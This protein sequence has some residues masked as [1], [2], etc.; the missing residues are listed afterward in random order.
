M[1]KNFTL[2]IFILLISTISNY[3]QVN[4]SFSATT[5]TYVPVTGGTTP[6]LINRPY[7][8][9][10]KYS[11]TYDEGIANGIPIGFTFNYNGIDY[12]TINICANGF[13]TL[14]T[15]FVSSTNNVENFYINSLKFGPLFYVYGTN[16]S[17][18]FP[19]LAGSTKPVLAPLWDDLNVQADANLRFITTGTAGSRIFTMEWAKAK[20]QYNASGSTISFELKL[21]EAANI[22]EFCYKDEGGT[23]TNA[24]ASIGITASTEIGGGF[25]SLQNTSASPTVST[26]V[27]SNSL[28]IKPANNQVYR[29]TPLTCNLPMNIH[30]QGYTNNAVNFS[31]DIPSGV[32]NFEYAVTT[33]TGDPASATSTTSNTAVVSSLQPD[34]KYYLHVRSYC[35]A[36]LQSVWQNSK[37]FK[38]AN[39]PVSLPYSE[40]FEADDPNSTALPENFREQ[41]FF[42]YNY[43]VHEW[44]S[45][46]DLP[47]YAHTGT[48]FIAHYT[49]VDKSNDW[50]YLPG[51][52]LN[53]GKTYK[54]KFYLATVTAGTK[55][56]SIE[57]KYG[58]A[59]GANA[60]LSG[61][62]FNSTNISTSDGA[63]K[64]DSAVF[65]PSASGIYFI[66]FHC[67]SEADDRDL[68]LDDI[69][70]EEI[71]SLP[72]TLLTLTG[73]VQ[74]KENL[75]HWSTV[76]EQ[77][78]TGFELQRSNDGY[79]FTK[80][81]FVK[82]KAIDGN[83]NE[84]LSYDFTDAAFTSSTNYYR[85]KQ[86]DKDGKFSYSNIVVLSNNIGTNNFITIYPNP[87]KNILN[88][89]IVPTTNSKINLVVTNVYGKN[90]LNK[91][92]N[93]GNI[94]TIVQLDV[95]QLPSGTY[96]VKIISEDGK[97]I[98]TQ[99]FIK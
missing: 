5:A 17:D 68:I 14:G 9:G 50:F 73:E 58:Q 48:Q 4:Y 39:N 95:S 91:N 41:N 47:E 99:K 93:V 23:S 21:Y 12:T 8:F 65:T 3:A 28:N 34:T 71:G 35:N 69:S 7:D 30:Y 64:A 2:I 62:L 57:V 96:F 44:E 13:A 54:L 33:S 49:S 98:A 51:F 53:V 29:F 72:V 97:E 31:W 11:F 79:N 78:N 43:D 84:K 55:P 20:W 85:L 40:G 60:M 87:V 76:T 74:H 38:A 19:E 59:I 89:K 77:N 45:R 94:E 63:Y 67:Y 42:Y 83:S 82:T 86:I 52:N 92:T 1:K 37:N 88:V 10:P 36:S 18:S 24:S 61:T 32:S 56:N 27:E 81:G 25:M 16:S 80:I 46:G 70:L 90:V 6:T 66:G 26:T 75:L 15:P 22:I